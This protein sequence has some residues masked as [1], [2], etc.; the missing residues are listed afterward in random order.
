MKKKKL[1]ASDILTTAILCLLTILFIFPFYWIM[2]GAFKSQP[3]TI[4][5][6]PQWWPK[7]PT[8]ENFKALIIQNPALKWLWNSI[9]ISV[10]TMLLVCGTSSLAGYALAKKRFYGQRLLFS[11]FIAAMALPKQVVLV[12]LVRIVNFMGIHDTLAAVILPLVGW[13]FGVFLMKQFSENIPTELLE[14]AKIDGC[15]EIRT[16]FNVAFPIIKPGFAALAIF[17]FINTW[18]DYFMQLVMLTSRDNLTISLGVATMQAEMATN[19][20]LIMAGAALAAV[21]IVTVFLVFQKSFTQG[22]TMGAVKG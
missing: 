12:P 7:A 8:V 18:N 3:D 19:Y 16:F 2:T 4:V 5:V 21:P 9:Y 22:I 17:T 20:G 14:S 11:I 10:A 6:P 13:P 1:T 15:G